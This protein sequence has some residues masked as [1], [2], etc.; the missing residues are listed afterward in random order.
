MVCVFQNKIY[1]GSIGHY[2]FCQ[3][4]SSSKSIVE[5]L[6]K[7]LH[8]WIVKTSRL[9]FNLMQKRLRDMNQLNTKSASQFKMI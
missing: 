4:Y 7:H 3:F 6:K 9:G 8:F 1:G 5:G 2:S